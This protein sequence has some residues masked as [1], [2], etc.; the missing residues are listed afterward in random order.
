MHA[1]IHTVD[2]PKIDQNEDSELA[3]FIDKYSTC[4]VPDETEYLKLAI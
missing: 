2:A 4:A 3:E 1:P